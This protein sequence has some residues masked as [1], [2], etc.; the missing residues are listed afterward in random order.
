MLT[1][2]LDARLRGHDEKVRERPVFQRFLSA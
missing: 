2:H 1:I